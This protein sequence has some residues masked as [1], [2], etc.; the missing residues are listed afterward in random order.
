MSELR[1]DSVKSK[2]GGAPNF[3]KGVTISGITTAVTLGATQIDG[4]N[5]NVSGVVT[6]GTLSGSLLSTGTPTLGLGVT[7]NSSGVAISGVAT[8]G[9]VSA[10]TLYGDGTNLTGI[11]A[12]IAPLFYNPDPYDTLAAIDTGIGI[13]FNQQVKAGTGNVTLS[14]ANAGVAGTVVENFG[15]GSSVTIS[16]NRVTINPTADLSGGEAQYFISYPSGAFTNNE[17]TDYV[18]TGYTFGTRSY[19]N[20][21]WVWGYNGE[22]RL[23]LNQAEPS[24]YS[25]PVQIPGTTWSANASIN[26]EDNKNYTFEYGGGVIKT[27]GTLWVWGR[28]QYGRL[29]QNQAE[30]QVGGYSSPVQVGS[31]TTWKTLMIG[32][33]NSYGI[34][35]IKTDGTLWAW[36]KNDFNSGGGQLGVNDTTHRSSPTQIPGTTWETCFMSGTNGGAVRTDGTLWT[37][38]R[39]NQVGPLGHNNTTDYSSP[40]QLP[41][42]DWA[43][44]QGGWDNS[45]FFLKT[46]GTLWVTGTGSSGQ[47]GLNATTPDYQGYSSPVQI[48]GTNWAKINHNAGY[49]S[50][51]GLKTDGTLWGWQNNGNGQLGLNDVA[52]RSSPA[53]IP[54]TT[55]SDI[56]N[57]S[58]NTVATK[59]D[60]T[61]WTWGKNSSGQLGQNSVGSPSNSGISSPVQ[62]PG[63]WAQGLAGNSTSLGIRQA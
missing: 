62:V 32:G 60:G 42:T 3:P 51:L 49:N 59:T 8:A 1:V 61:L 33:G 16:E 10:T 28:N 14:I 57:Y 13:T 34:S 9:I 12:T 22:G 31:D 11:G 44:V 25:S 15:V 53:Q 6:S 17:G 4:S 55:W 23:G 63:L 40:K 27:D 45:M 5:V 19:V 56:S 37:W 50:V 43:S 48:P 41:G 58:G 47:L 2:G 20:Q 35:A 38:G 36:G 7:I 39:G 54:G 26:A 18:G 46:D 52:Q 30:A 24:Q 21:L 29:G